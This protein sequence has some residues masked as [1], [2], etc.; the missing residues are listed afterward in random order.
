MVL[1]V[2]GRDYI[3]PK[4]RQYIPT[5]L[6][7]YNPTWSYPKRHLQK[8]G[9]TA[10]ANFVYHLSYKRSNMPFMHTCRDGHHLHCI[11]IYIC[12][13]FYIH[14]SW[15]SRSTLYQ[16][17]LRCYLSR[18]FSDF[19]EK[20]GVKT[21]NFKSP[22]LGWWS[23]TAPTQLPDLSLPFPPWGH[24]SATCPPLPPLPYLITVL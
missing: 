14:T 10:S 11:Y 20:N 1:V 17:V 12:M 19:G 15:Y 2:C 22:M 24:T 5:Q 16:Y 6:G 13:F 7:D 4:P 23:A 8:P 9:L 21:V 3:T 18:R